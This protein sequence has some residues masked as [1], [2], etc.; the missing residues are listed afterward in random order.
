LSLKYI[1]EKTALK[2]QIKTHDKRLF[3]KRISPTT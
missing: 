2:F 3:L 1:Q